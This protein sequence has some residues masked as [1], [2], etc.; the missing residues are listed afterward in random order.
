MDSDV[1]DT[2]NHV[3]NPLYIILGFF[4]ITIN[5]LILYIII[6]KFTTRSTEIK[7]TFIL[8]IIE[9]I[10]GLFMTG[11]AIA[12][13]VVGY[14]W[15][16]SYSIQCI[17][18]ATIDWTSLRFGLFT[19]AILSTLRY[20]TVC[21]KKEKSFKFWI[22]TW[23]IVVSP[24]FALFF[25]IPI[26]QDAAHT[27][28][29]LFC[30]IFTFPS[31]I[32]SIFIAIMPFT[33]LIPCWIITFC[34]CCIG[35]TANKQLNI[36]KSQAIA[37]NDESLLR[38]LKRQ[39]LKL[40]GQILVVFIVYNANYMISYVTQILKYVIGYKRPPLLDA[41]TIILLNI[42][43]AVN[44][45]ITITFQPELNNELSLLLL[46]FNPEIN[47]GLNQLLLKFQIKMK[48]LFK[49]FFPSQ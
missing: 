37:D 43:A 26:N 42:P 14:T 25:Y 32:L 27:S 47:S 17:I 38:V 4:I 8:C 15:L 35:Y 46:K 3:F 33:F 9:S 39:K 45:L 22:I 6:A 19:L 24:I 49:K 23:L 31:P 36:I 48:S 16:S 2:I 40:V 30:T 5:M 28:S 13:L 12:K 34:Y 7:L 20:L 41:V 29:W 11:L 44:P 1:L 21:H 10:Q 18:E